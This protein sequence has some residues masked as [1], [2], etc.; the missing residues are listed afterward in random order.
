MPP[1]I[2]PLEIAHVPAEIRAFFDHV[3][4]EQC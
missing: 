1:G 3:K 2:T 4:Q